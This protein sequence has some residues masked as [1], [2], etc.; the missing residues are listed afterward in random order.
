[1]V[2]GTPST[3]ICARCGWQNDSTARM[4]GGCGAPLHTSDPG[5]TNQANAT[6]PDAPTVAS[7]NVPGAYVAQPYVQPTTPP[8]IPQT[9]TPV[10]AA[11]VAWPGPGQAKAR[12]GRDTFRWW[13]VPLVIL[14]AILVLGGLGFGVWNFGIQPSTASS[15]NTT[16][17]AVL[18]PTFNVVNSSFTPGKNGQVQIVAPALAE[19]ITAESPHSG[20]V[21]NLHFSFINAPYVGFKLTYNF[22]FFGTELQDTT[23]AFS[24]EQGHLAARSTVVN[25]SMSLFESGDQMEQILN[26]ALAKLTTIQGKVVSFKLKGQVLTIQLMQS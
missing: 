19:L 12:S 8:P 22:N 16:F 9:P 3:I 14:V 7:A 26:N 23:A 6:S 24:I 25:G 18:N 11:P 1:M 15:V 13:V 17:P 20:P 10:T 21:T 2:P 4:C 5:A